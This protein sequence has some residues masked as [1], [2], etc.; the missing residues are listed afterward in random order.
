MKLFYSASLLGRPI[1]LVTSKREKN[2]SLSLF[3]LSLSLS[4]VNDL[5][6]LFAFENVDFLEPP[7]NYFWN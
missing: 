2:I 5:N 3:S 4:P 7:K 6:N 1:E